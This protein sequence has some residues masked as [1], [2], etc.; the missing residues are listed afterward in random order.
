MSS[1]RDPS[2]KK[3]KLLARV[4]QQRVRDSGVALN[5]HNGRIIFLKLASAEYAGRDDLS[6]R[7]GLGLAVSALC[8][9]AA[10]MAKI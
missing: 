3:R 7:V 2:L 8:G 4:R 10:A 9:R 1:G 5:R 6:A